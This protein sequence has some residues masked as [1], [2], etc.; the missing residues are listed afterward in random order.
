[1]ATNGRRKRPL[2]SASS[3]PT[4]TMLSIFMGNSRCPS[5]QATCAIMPDRILRN[6][7]DY[8]LHIAFLWFLVALA[9]LCHLLVPVALPGFGGGA[10]GDHDAAFEGENGFAALVVGDGFDGDNAAIGFAARLP[11]VQYGGFGVDGVA[12]E[13][14][15]E[16]AHVLKFEV[17]DGLAAHVWDRHAKHDAENEGADYEA[18]PVLRPLAVEG[19]DVQGVVVHGE[20]TEQG[21]V[22]LGNGA[23][24]PVFVDG[25]DFKVFKTATKLHV[26]LLI[27]ACTLIAQNS[28]PPS[29]A[30]LRSEG[31]GSIRHPNS[32]KR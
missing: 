7:D 4:P 14:G 28:L 5:L 18:L 16:V 30:T 13:G 8:L 19:V 17:G 32:H 3:A 12:V 1:M 9:Q 15:A 11:L 21:V 22:V 20:H 23:A 25:T 10:G 31:A 27:M 2:P 29:D 24:R 6:G 26:C